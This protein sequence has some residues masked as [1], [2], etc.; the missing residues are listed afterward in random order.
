MEGQQTKKQLI[1]EILRFLL[2]GA[3]ATVADY[4]TF[5][6]LRNFALGSY[7][8]P[9]KAFDVFSLIV[10]TALGFGVGLLVNWF[11][12]VRFVFAA[13][14]AQSKERLKSAFWKFTLV[15][16]IGLAI[17]ELGMHLFVFALP[18]IKIGAMKEFLNLPLQEWLAKIVMTAIVLVWNYL[19]RKLWVFRN[20]ADE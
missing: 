14:K 19:G 16:L 10:S 7:L 4:L 1:L 15:A 18:E 9:T 5:Y 2:V 17:T 3:L 20:R 13:A 6:L 11:L 8:V 12:S